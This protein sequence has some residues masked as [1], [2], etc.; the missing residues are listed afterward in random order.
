MACR[1]GGVGARQRLVTGGWVVGGVVIGVEGRVVGGVVSEPPQPRRASTGMMPSG[2]R[3]TVVLFM[4][5]LPSR[6]RTSLSRAKVNREVPGWPIHP[7]LN[8][9]Y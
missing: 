4:L 1:G 5:V 3:K 9:G 6:T 2:A 7:F 8:L